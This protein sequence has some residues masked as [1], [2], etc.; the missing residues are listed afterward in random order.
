MAD[1]SV[2][3]AA[4][5]PPLVTMSKPPGPLSPADS[6]PALTAVSTTQ[7]LAAETFNTTLLVLLGTWPPVQLALSLHKPWPDGL[8]AG[9]Q[10][11]VV[12][13]AR[14]HSAGQRSK[15][16]VKARDPVRNVII[17][18]IFRT[19]QKGSGNGSSIFYDW[20]ICLSRSERQAR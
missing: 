17:W 10:T 9:F 3:L 5:L 4:R 8:A 11:V 12:S 6:W 2:A 14:A 16:A 13:C 15:P 18:P 19:I 20:R 1:Q 7:A